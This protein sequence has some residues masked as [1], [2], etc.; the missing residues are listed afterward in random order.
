MDINKITNYLAVV[1]AV[2]ILSTTAYNNIQNK[3]ND[4]QCLSWG[5]V[6]VGGLAYIKGNSFTAIINKV[7]DKKI[8]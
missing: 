4:W 1:Y 6:A 8:K 5:L 7:V 2:V 3:T